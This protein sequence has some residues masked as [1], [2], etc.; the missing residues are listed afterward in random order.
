MRK[1][2]KVEFKFLALMV[3][4]C[5]LLSL[6]LFLV[7]DTP[8]LTMNFINVQKEITPQEL[9][10]LEQEGI[11]ASDLEKLLREYDKKRNK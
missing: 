11:T 10:K 5:F 3:I 1:K 2:K 4:I 7:F 6:L 9:E 8:S